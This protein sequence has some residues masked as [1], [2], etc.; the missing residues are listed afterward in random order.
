MSKNPFINLTNEARRAR[1][2]ETAAKLAPIV[3]ELDRMFASLEAAR[4]TTC[5]IRG[6]CR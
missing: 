6:L 3:K 2:V 5:K 1:A 4:L